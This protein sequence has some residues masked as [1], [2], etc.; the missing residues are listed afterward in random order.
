[1]ADPSAPSR[2]ILAFY[3]FVRIADDIADHATLEPD[4][5]L[6]LL[7]RLEADLLGQR[8]D[9]PEAVR[10]ARR[11]PSAALS[12][13]HAQ[14]L[15][16]RVPASMSPSCAI[17]T[18]TTSSTIA[19]YSAMP[20]GRFVLDVHGESRSHLAGQRC[21]LRGAADH[22]PPAG[23]RRRTTAT[24][25][26]SMCRS[27]PWPRTALSVEELGR[28][29]GS[30]AL[31]RCLHDLA[32]AH[33]RLLR[34]GRRR[35]PRM[36]NDLRLAL[37]VSVIHTL[38]RRIVAHADARDPLSER[39]HLA[40]PAR[41]GAGASARLI[42]ARS[43]ALGGRGRQSARK[44][45][46]RERAWTPPQPAAR[47][48][49]R[50]SG[51]SFYTAMRILPRAQREAMFEIYSFCR[52]VDD[53]ADDPRPAR[54]SGSP[55]S[56]HGATDIDALYDGQRRRQRRRAWRGRCATFDLQREDFLAVID[57]MEMDV[58]ADIR[59]P[60]RADARSLLRSRRERGRTALG[61]RVRH[62]ARTPA[63]RSRII[64]AARCSSPTSC[65][66]STRTPRIGRLY[67][68]RE[69][70][71]AGRHRDRP[72]RATVVG[73]S[74]ASAQACAPVVARAREH[75]AEADRI[76]ARSRR[77][78]PCARRASW[79]RP[80]ASILEKLVARGWAAPRAPVNVSQAA[81]R[82]DHPA[83]RVHLMPRT[84]PH[85]RRRPRRP[86]P[87][88]SGSTARGAARRRA[89]GDRAGRRALP[90]LSRSRDSA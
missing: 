69:A 83:L 4:E 90:L 82:P 48:P 20:V 26:A 38:A 86:R 27:M 5:K 19:R 80:I 77:A 55:S 34:R 57:G 23:L 32:D 51:S 63:L 62:G 13:R 14:D 44:R 45:R 37:E 8:D 89:R 54:R 29:A 24:S 53:I 88:R 7:D 58:V 40:K 61:A 84:D 75:F 39:V 67:L 65:A 6:A 31:L 50:A 81:T 42:A 15:L 74:R 79:A 76:M 22:Q 46:M 21:A 30:P 41:R 3:E 68:P 1:M 71:H 60:D 9:D 11:L 16:D 47:A 73:A 17:A 72:I 43:A 87:P 2:P 33:R 56:P 35:S 36:I 18:G 52:A 10:C 25:T 28:A 85:H 64:S 12:P 66:I 78:A 49:Q 59:A 70:L